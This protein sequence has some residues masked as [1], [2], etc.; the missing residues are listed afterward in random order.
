MGNVVC[1]CEQTEPPQL[2]EIEIE[3]L[4]LPFD[5]KV[6]QRDCHDLLS[7]KYYL[8]LVQFIEHTASLNAQ[9]IRDKFRENRRMLYKQGR[10]KEYGHCIGAQIEAGKMLARDVEEKILENLGITK[11]ELDNTHYVRL[12]NH[13]LSNEI[14]C[15]KV[16]LNS[17]ISEKKPHILASPIIKSR[18]LQML[19]DFN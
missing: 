9:G 19:R 2:D 12:N 17:P 10:W 14:N 5:L 3:I 1:S 11:K 7:T 18:S 8:R 15:A 6:V 4:D 13:K 16:G